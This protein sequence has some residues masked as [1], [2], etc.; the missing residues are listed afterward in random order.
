M[1]SK[2]KLPTETI[3]NQDFLLEWLIPSKRQ[4][5]KKEPSNI[6]CK[7]RSQ[8]NT[9]AVVSKNT[10]DNKNLILTPTL[11]LCLKA[12]KNLKAVV[13]TKT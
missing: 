9:A 6:P 10:S 13:L 5:I 8:E 3:R 7:I 4:E 2:R 12:T 1:K 11:K